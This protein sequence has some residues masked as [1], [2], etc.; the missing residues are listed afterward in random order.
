MPLSAVEMILLLDAY[1][2]TLSAV[3]NDPNGARPGVY[4]YLEREQ[5]DPPEPIGI[6]AV[7]VIA[8][9]LGISEQAAAAWWD[10][11][12]AEAQAREDAQADGAAEG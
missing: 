3:D 4:R 8:E 9:R 11:K 5:L 6:P 1:F 10:R 7:R 2:R 12:Q